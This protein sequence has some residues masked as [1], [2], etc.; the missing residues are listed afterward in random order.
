M[1]HPLTRPL[2][3]P[4]LPQTPPLQVCLRSCGWACGLDCSPLPVT[5]HLHPLFSV[6]S[7]LFLKPWACHC[8]LS[9]QGLCTAET[10]KTTFTA[11]KAILTIRDSATGRH[12]RFSMIMMKLDLAPGLHG[13]SSTCSWHSLRGDVLVSLLWVTMGLI[14]TTRGPI[15]RWVLLRVFL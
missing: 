7:F 4:P 13:G 12:R 8:P 10:C 6:P 9:L 14:M 1:N 2:K 5:L 3:L 11:C 15:L